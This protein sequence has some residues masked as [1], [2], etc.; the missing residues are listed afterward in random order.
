VRLRRGPRNRIGCPRLNQLSSEVCAVPEGTVCASAECLQPGALGQSSCPM[1]T[2]SSGCPVGCEHS[3]AKLRAHR[4][5]DAEMLRDQQNWSKLLFSSLI[6]VARTC[7]CRPLFIP[8][9]SCTYVDSAASN[10]PR[11][12]PFLQLIQTSDTKSSPAERCAAG[13]RCLWMFFERE[14]LWTTPLQRLTNRQSLLWMRSA[15]TPLYLCP[16]TAASV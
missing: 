2:P 1:G 13:E 6:C 5:L 12:T 4:P 14:F 16:A 11:T 15:V 3:G 8:H 10:Q 7:A 9:Y